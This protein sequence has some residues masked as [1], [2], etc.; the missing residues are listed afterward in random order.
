MNNKKSLANSKWSLFYFILFAGFG[1]YFLNNVVSAQDIEL[2]D[3]DSISTSGGQ[4]SVPITMRGGQT[5]SNTSRPN[6][7]NS[8]SESAAPETQPLKLQQSIVDDKGKPLI[9]GT[10]EYHLP[11]LR[12]DGKAYL[13]SPLQ[14]NK[15]IIVRSA[16]TPN[17]IKVRMKVE[18][19]T[20]K[21]IKSGSV[22][23]TSY[24]V[25][26]K[27]G[28]QTKYRRVY[29]R[30]VYDWCR[31]SSCLKS[32]A[33]EVKQCDGAGYDTA[34]I[35]FKNLPK[36]ESGQ[37]E[38]FI[39]WAYPLKAG[40][41]K[42]RFR[43]INL[44]TKENYH[45]SR[46][47]LNKDSFKV[48]PERKSKKNDKS[49]ID[50]VYADGDEDDAGNGKNDVEQDQPTEYEK[51]VFGGGVEHQTEGSGLEGGQNGSSSVKTKIICYDE[52]N[53]IIPD[54]GVS[55]KRAK[56]CNEEKLTSSE[57]TLGMRNKKAQQQFIKIQSLAG[58]KGK[59]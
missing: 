12:F 37:L 24:R 47:F 44:E 39:L 43:L 53:N 3:E 45:I 16:L 55:P 23:W 59:I 17:K 15:A 2:D 19:Y 29:Q 26:Y 7:S 9:D 6:N 41:K 18:Y 1:A 49:E 22:K 20:V 27:C 32:T 11:V 58:K 56:K 52:F 54:T 10:K 38:K 46:K 31:V 4:T 8:S 33:M 40:S 5:S 50:D 57:E 13:E 34:I 25:P 14:N 51:V 35:H 30:E 42:I 48:T 28:N 36:L 21:K